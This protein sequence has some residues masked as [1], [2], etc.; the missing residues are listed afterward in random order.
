ERVSNLS[1][2]GIFVFA[3]CLS[4]ATTLLSAV[5]AY[6]ALTKLHFWK[7]QGKWLA[8]PLFLVL[9]AAL[10]Y[11]LGYFINQTVRTLPLIAEKAI[12]SVIQWFKE[13]QI[14][15]PFTDYDDLKDVAFDAVRSQVHYLGSFAKFARGATT[16]FVFLI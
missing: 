3:G 9:V 1:L 5:F 2:A 4:L 13:H 10:A 6:L 14:E 11:S 7:R 12:P 16:Q 15:P 8:V